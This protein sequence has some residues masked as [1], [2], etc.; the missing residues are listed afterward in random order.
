M[1]ERFNFWQKYVFFGNKWQAKKKE[2][3]QK[4]FHYFLFFVMY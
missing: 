3:P 1:A 2:M 4:P